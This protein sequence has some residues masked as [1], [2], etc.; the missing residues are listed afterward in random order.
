M[1]N[2]GKFLKKTPEVLPDRSLLKGQKLAGKCQNYNNVT[3]WG[4]FLNTVFT[5]SVILA[6]SMMCAI[7]S[8]ASQPIK[9]FAT[10]LFILEKKIVAYMKGGY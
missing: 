9:Q 2:I 7:T 10:F 8:I 5:Q 4:R 3:F 6:Y 1:N